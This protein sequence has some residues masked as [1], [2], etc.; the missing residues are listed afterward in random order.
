MGTSPRSDYL[1]KTYIGEDILKMGDI[2]TDP[3]GINK[4]DFYMGV[5]DCRNL[6]GDIS[7]PAPSRSTCRPPKIAA[8]PGCRSLSKKEW[9]S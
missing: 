9:M 1:R 6:L 4:R 2:L 7:A 8:D 3:Q 5:L